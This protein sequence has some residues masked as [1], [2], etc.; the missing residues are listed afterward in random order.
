[1]QM[2]NPTEGVGNGQLST[3]SY[4]TISPSISFDA[5]DAPFPIFSPALI[6]PSTRRS[7]TCTVHIRRRLRRRGLYYAIEAHA[8]LCPNIV[9]EDTKL[10]T[11]PCTGIIHS[12]GDSY[13]GE[14]VEDFPSDSALLLLVCLLDWDYIQFP[15][16]S[17]Q[18]VNRP[19][20][21]DSCWK[22][23]MM[24]NRCR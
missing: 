21:N 11:G 18:K 1:M 15:R 16:P 20:T 14:T 7:V 10:H 4:Y 5:A 2:S 3:G 13:S 8:L 12:E 6:F 22:R 23:E 24:A 19:I 17:H 9:S